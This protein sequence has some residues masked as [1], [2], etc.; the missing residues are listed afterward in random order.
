M[1]EKDKQY[2]K[3]KKGLD[4]ALA[5]RLRYHRTSTRDADGVIMIPD[6][7]RNEE[8]WIKYVELHDELLSSPDFYYQTSDKELVI[9]TLTPTQHIAKKI[10]HLPLAERNRIYAIAKR[11][12]SLCGLVSSTKSKAI[13]NKYTLEET[14]A[15]GP[16]SMHKGFFESRGPEILEY[17]GRYFST[18]EVHRIITQEWGYSVSYDVL[19]RWRLGHTERISELQDE[20]KSKYSDVRLGYKRSRLDELTYLYNTRLD[21]YR[22][23]K[24]REDSKELR[25]ILNQVK[26]EVEGDVLTINGRIDVSHSL[27]TEEFVRHELMSH[28][29][30]KMLVIARV[31]ERIG[32]NPLL[33]QYQLINSYYAKL[34]GFKKA[35]VSI[36]D[37]DIVYPSSLIYDFDSLRQRNQELNAE[38]AE[39]EEMINSDNSGVKSVDPEDIKS[40]V[41][42]MMIEKRAANNKTEARIIEG[43]VS[44]E[45]TNKT[46][47]NGNS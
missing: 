2:H 5:K 36:E 16:R 35:D 44:P 7:V 26:Q 40:R 14:G 39:F 24:N 47:K 13:G 46:K 42:K 23:N 11:M 8:A 6:Y 3:S 22:E 37:D 17:F 15:V 28:M 30:I 18:V 31:A 10:S 41:A 12:R 45:Q 32:R 25:A 38:Y 1:G 9:N 33:L 34:T 20:F 43:S 19:K 27:R 4:T 21:L 29:N